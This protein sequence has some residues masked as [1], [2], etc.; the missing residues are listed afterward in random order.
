[1]RIGGQFWYKPWRTRSGWFGKLV[2]LH[3]LMG[4]HPLFPGPTFSSAL[5]H[6]WRVYDGLPTMKRLLGLLSVFVTAE[7]MPTVHR[8]RQAAESLM[9]SFAGEWDDV[10]LSDWSRERNLFLSLCI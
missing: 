2:R 4:N 7:G 9:R 5:R 10:L 8:A 1:M 6:L 3:V